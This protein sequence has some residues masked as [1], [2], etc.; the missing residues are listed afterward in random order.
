MGGMCGDLIACLIDSSDSVVRMG[1][2]FTP[3]NRGKL[4]KSD[5]FTNDEEKDLYIKQIEKKYKS[6]PS[7]DLE[8]HIRRKHDFI[9]IVVSD[10]EVA[11]WAAE[12]FKRL[13][14]IEVWKNV[15]KNSQ[16][17]SIKEYANILLLSSNII[18]DNTDKIINLED[19]IKGKAIDKLQPH[20]NSQ[21]NDNFYKEWLIGQQT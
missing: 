4:K 16:I 12:R 20:V 21:L 5:S 13:H 6:I 18:K 11:N 10:V 17:D 9:S 1:R 7:H 14:K 15:S 19:I 3:M 2:V 8:Y